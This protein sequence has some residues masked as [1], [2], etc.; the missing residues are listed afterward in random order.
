MRRILI[1]PAHTGHGGLSEIQQFW[2]LQFANLQIHN[3]QRC[4]LG[5]G[6]RRRERCESSIVSCELGIEL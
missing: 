5:L 6:I 3:L 2:N 4:K 1:K